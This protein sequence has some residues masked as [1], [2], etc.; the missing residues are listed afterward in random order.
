MI[1]LTEDEGLAALSRVYATRGYVVLARGS[2]REPYQPGAIIKTGIKLFSGDA[3]SLP[4]PFRVVSQ[5]TLEDYIEQC[6]M[7]GADRK[8][9][10]NYYGGT[11]FTFYR[12]ESD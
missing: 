4:Q 1:Q 6:V 9:I 11:S 7:V 3:E 8:M 12:V 10:V 2:R 5:T